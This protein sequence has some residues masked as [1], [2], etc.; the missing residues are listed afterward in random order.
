MAKFSENQP[1]ESWQNNVG[2]C[3]QKK[4]GCVQ[5]VQVRHCS[6]TSPIAPKVSW[7]LSATWFAHVCCVLWSGLIGL[8]RSN[9]KNCFFPDLQSH[10]NTCM[11]TESVQWNQ[12]VSHTSS[13]GLIPPT[14]AQHPPASGGNGGERGRGGR[15]KGKERE[16]EKGREGTPTVGW[17]PHVPNPEKHPEWN[18]TQ[19][20]GHERAMTVT[21]LCICNTYC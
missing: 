3:G 16:L 15:G 13:G 1:P 21:R 6:R 7:T 12:G 20:V 2:F 17:H 9:F 5:L 18:L 10:Y 4:P 8:C 14:F 19:N 11:Q